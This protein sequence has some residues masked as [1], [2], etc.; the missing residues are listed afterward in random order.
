MK[1]AQSRQS[2]CNPMDCRL[3]CLTF[4]SPRDLSN[5]GFKPGS[6]A[7]QADSLWTEPPGKLRLKEAVPLRRLVPRT[8][9]GGGTRRDQAD[10]AGQL[11]EWGEDPTP[12]PCRPHL[13]ATLCV[14]TR[15]TQR[16]FK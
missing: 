5:P 9:R 7:L 6:P 10:G 14:I 8:N 15:L 11:V 2:L 1:V 13:I 12:A 16:A 3:P 4:P